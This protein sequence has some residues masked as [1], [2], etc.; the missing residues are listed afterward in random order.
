MSRSG[1]NDVPNWH[2]NPLYSPFV[3]QILGQILA[4]DAPD[5]V[6]AYAAYRR[7]GEAIGPGF[8]LDRTY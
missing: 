3:A 1:T 4:K 2:G 5:A 7:F 6:T 8:R